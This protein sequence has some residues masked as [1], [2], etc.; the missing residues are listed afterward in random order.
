MYLNWVK[1]IPWWNSREPMRIR[2][3]Y[4]SLRWLSGNG[5]HLDKLPL[6]WNFSFLSASRR[7]KKTQHRNALSTLLIRWAAKEWISPTPPRRPLAGGYCC[8]AGKPLR[9]HGRLRSTETHLTVIAPH[10]H[11]Y[12]RRAVCARVCVECVSRTCD[13]P[14]SPVIITNRVSQ[15][16]ASK[17]VGHRAGIKQQNNGELPL[18]NLL[19][20]SQWLP[21]LPKNYQPLD[22]LTSLLPP[23]RVC[24]CVWGVC[25][26][27]CVW[28][29]CRC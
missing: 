7:Q 12:N 19:M 6:M 22:S 13:H 9:P 21:R 3:R 28:I 17:S 18:L 14:L 20:G 16:P 26:G 1:F 2:K 15:A 11:S 29:E 24:M 4:Q 10:N 23:G 27:W 25:R 8:L 5:I